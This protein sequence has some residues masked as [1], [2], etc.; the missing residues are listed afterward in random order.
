MAGRSITSANSIFTL[1]ISDL[2]P[3]PVQLQ[4]FSADNIFSTDP[5]DAA[6]VLMGL[7]GKLSAGFVYVPAV[8]HIEL[9]ADSDSNRLFEQWQAEQQRDA[10]LFYAQGIVILQSIGTT[11]ALTKGVLKTYPPMPDS[12]KTLRPRRYGITWEKVSPAGVL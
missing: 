6:E 3:A 5:M 4:G 7:D 8:Q 2:F 12:A 1:S 11:W 10:D 9:Q